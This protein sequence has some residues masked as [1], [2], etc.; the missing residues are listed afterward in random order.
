MI[1][2]V[3]QSKSAAAMRNTADLGDLKKNSSKH[4][5]S[6]KS[7]F[8]T[9]YTE[10]SQNVSHHIF[11][12]LVLWLLGKEFVVINMGCSVQ[13]NNNNIFL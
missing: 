12:V 7:V 10:L 13:D 6:T 11:N 4:F 8:Q 2:P 5:D 1:P 3:P 9:F